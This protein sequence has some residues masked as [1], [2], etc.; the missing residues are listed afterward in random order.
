MRGYLLG[1]G[2]VIVG[3]LPVDKVPPSIKVLGSGI[4]VVNVVG[5]FPHVACEQGHQLVVL[6]HSVGIMCVHNLHLAGLLVEN[7]PGPATGEVSCG[8]LAELL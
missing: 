4:A 3:K 2:E 7:Q 1:F 8:L 5:M 6:H